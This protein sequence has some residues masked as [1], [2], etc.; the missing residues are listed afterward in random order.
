MVHDEQKYVTS[1][2]DFIAAK[3]DKERRRAPVRESGSMSLGVQ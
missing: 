3:V 2:S 1:L